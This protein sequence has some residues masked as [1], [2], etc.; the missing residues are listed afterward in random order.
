MKKAILIF[1]MVFVTMA[2]SQN[3]GMKWS[4]KDR[5]DY[6]YINGSF[7]LNMAVG[8]KDNPD[9]AEFNDRGLDFDVEVGARDRHVG[10]YI[11]YGRFDAMDYQNYGAG[12]DY[13]VHWLRQKDVYLYNPFTGRR[14]KVIHGIDMSIGVAYGTVIRWNNFAFNG[15]HARAITTI[16]FGENFGFTMRFQLTK[17]GDLPNKDFRKE[18]A[19]GFT[20]KFNRN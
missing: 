17:A 12:V 2:F 11:F 19:I 6:W 5:P 16:W 10:V 1:A 13:Y 8:I 14:G 15:S 7:D 20:Y 9:T 3:Y 4:E 18:G